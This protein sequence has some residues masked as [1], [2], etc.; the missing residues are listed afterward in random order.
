MLAAT[1]R[2]AGSL[3]VAEDCAQE[4]F[5]SALDAWTRAGIPANPGAW[6][7]TTARRKALDLH[8]R[9]QVLRTKL[10]LLAAEADPS[11]TTL[12][13]PSEPDEFD[14]AEPAIPDDRLRLIFTCCHPAL[15][16]EAQVALTLRLVCGLS[17]ADIARAFLVSEPTMAARMTRAKKKIAGAAIPY[18]VPAGHELAER[19][20]AVLTVVH[21][22]F[23]AGYAA[24]S[25]DDLMRPELAD[26]A[27][28]LARLLIE[29]MPDER[30]VY[31]LLALMLLTDARR[32][33]R[34]AA[35]GSLV[36]LADQ[37]RSRWDQ[38]QIAEGQRALVAG[39]R[40]LQAGRFV[41]QAAIAAQHARAASY[42][43]T[44][45][46]QIVT[47]YDLLLRVWP[48]P[49]VEL[50]RAVAISMVQ[51]PQAGLDQLAGINLP[52]YHYLPAAR[53]DLLRQLGRLDEA[54][55]AYDQAIE[56]VHNEAERRFLLGQQARVN[57]SR[58][59][60]P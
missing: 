18:R 15:A 39:L 19:L 2:V 9:N 25:G 44:D 50:N 5:V 49:V 51:G 53:A 46:A 23:N 47:L 52:N 16:R 26:Q 48:S 30:E 24:P 3:D 36:L 12:P 33:T 42:Q 56:W 8:R 28:R 20:D 41:L 6:L 22:V 57:G 55:Q 40:G 38:D 21:L 29:L 14:Q 11:R 1:V 35:D 13:L 4:A 7:T 27:I 58:D 10:P 54:A 31:G 37:D 59:P 34:T 32:A 45:W 17:T 60:A 43:R